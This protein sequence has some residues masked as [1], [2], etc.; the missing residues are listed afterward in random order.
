MGGTSGGEED[1]TFWIVAF[2]TF[3]VLPPDSPSVGRVPLALSPETYPVEVM[4]AEMTAN[5]LGIGGPS[6]PH[7]RKPR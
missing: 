6:H 7:P 5:T 3:C 1:R 2:G 4:G